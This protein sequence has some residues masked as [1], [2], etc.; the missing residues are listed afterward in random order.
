MEYF[1]GSGFAIC[2]G[3]THIFINHPDGSQDMGKLSE[4]DVQ[5]EIAKKLPS[6]SVDTFEDRI[7]T[8]TAEDCLYKMHYLL[9]KKKD[10]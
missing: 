1:A 7:H 2:I 4:N 8:T 5:V 10:A 9:K 3:S 6:C